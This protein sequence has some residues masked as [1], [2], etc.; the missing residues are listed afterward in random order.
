MAVSQLERAKR[1]LERAKRNR[2]V[3]EAAASAV[4][5]SELG[6]YTEKAVKKSIKKG[7]T[8]ATTLEAAGNSQAANASEV[9][10][11]KVKKIRK[12][13]EPQAI[14]PAA[15]EEVSVSKKKKK[16]H[17]IDD[18]AEEHEAKVDETVAPEKKH[19]LGKRERVR[20][21]KER[22]RLQAKQAKQADDISTA[23]AVQ[24]RASAEVSDEKKKKRKAEDRDS[25]Q[26]DSASA[27]SKKYK[28]DA[29]P[30]PAEG[31]GWR[32]IMD[33]KNNQKVFVGGI[34]FSVDLDTLQSDFAE[35]GEVW[36]FAYPKNE[37]GNFK[38][39]AFFTFKTL[40]G[41]KNALAYDGTD[42]WGRT[43]KVGMATPLSTASRSNG[44]GKW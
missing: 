28:A 31:M 13:K 29:P 34:P 10:T 18:A 30:A 37:D 25:A 40:D 27:K 4:D 16:Q 5:N 36:D 8:H 43:L 2:E 44:K 20:A 12:A 14:E 19:K 39:M 7:N 1:K 32:E 17:N 9:P 35:C 23:K 42:Y 21:A 41:V 15:V 6:N 38:G 3:E 24:E 11:K 22:D 33:M 26:D